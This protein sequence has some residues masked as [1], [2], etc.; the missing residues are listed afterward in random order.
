[1]TGA[2]ISEVGQMVRQARAREFLCELRWQN[3]QRLPVVVT[4][5][6]CHPADRV[7]VIS[8]DMICVYTWRKKGGTS[9]G[10]CYARRPTGWTLV[11]EISMGRVPIPH[12]QSVRVPQGN[13]IRIFHEAIK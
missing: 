5:F 2:E 13:R 9:V 6:F 12:F 3:W 7:Q 1:M 11:V 8:N 10:H 4:Q